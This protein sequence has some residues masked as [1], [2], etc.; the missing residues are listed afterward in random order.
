ML[1]VTTSLSTGFLDPAVS[2]GRPE[3]A[4]ASAPVSG[5]EIKLKLARAARAA[6]DLGA[7]I[8]LYRQVADA[9][10][11]DPGLRVELGDTLLEAGLIDDAIGAYE[12]VRPDAKAKLHALLGL[13]NAYARL[14]QPLTALDY[15]KRAAALSP[16]DEAAQVSLGVSL[17]LVSRHQEAQA[18]Y[19][20]ALAAAPR[21]V[22]ARS[23]LALSLAL[24]GQFPE[25][26]T[27]LKPIASSAN[28]S[29]QARQNLALVYGLA[30]DRAQALAWS[31]ADLAPKEAEA[32]EALFD[33][34]R[35]PP[36]PA[37]SRAQN[38]TP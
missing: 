37:P 22:A 5:P 15:A 38:P 25:A 21:S 7:A 34:A 32:N 33:S 10:K 23:D 17:D 29:G 24:T 13:R 20:T 35:T 36:P 31:Q 4:R 26:L 27:L 12:T 3:E 9:P 28:A 14:G 2:G 6:G 11:A 1:A 8:P 16:Q 30:G 19:R 18:A